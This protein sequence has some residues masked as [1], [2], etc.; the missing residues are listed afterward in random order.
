MDIREPRRSPLRNLSLVWLVPLLAL[1]VTLGVAWQNFADRGTLIQIAFD[2]AQGVLPGETA[3]RYRDVVVGRVKDVDFTTGL[4]R[5]LVSARID[6]DV[7]PYL[8]AD[9]DFWVVRPEVSARGIEGLSTVL[10]GVY[11]EGAWDGERGEARTAFDGRDGPPLVQP[12]RPGKRITLRTENGTTISKGAPVL[13]RGVQVG[14]LEAPRLAQGGGFVLVDAFVDAPH[15]AL[16]TGGVRFWDTSGF[17]V[18]FG[19]GGF[20]LDFDS[21]ASLVTGGLSFA[22][23]YDGGE[24]VDAGAVFDIFP[25]EQAARRS[26]F[27]P[28]AVGSVTLSVRFD[29]NVGGLNAGADVTFRGL[30]VGQVDGLQS[31]VTETDAGPEVELIA[32]ITV[33]PARIG[34]AADAGEDAVFDFF[35]EAVANGLR[36]RLSTQ[37]FFSRDL[38]VEIVELPEAAPAAFDRSAEPNPRLPS[39][40]SDLPDV[41]ATAQG[42]LDRVNDLPLEEVLDQ[43]ISLMASIEDVARS[44]GTRQTPDAVLALV[45]DTRALI[46]AEE[47]QA[48]PG[49]LNAIVADL[50]AV[51]A[52]LRE[53]GATRDLASALESLDAV[54]SDLAQGSD[55]LPE[56]LGNLQR[57][58]EEAAALDTRALANEARDALENLNALLSDEALQTLPPT[59]AD[60]ASRLRTILRDIDE[61]GAVARLNAALA[62]LETVGADAAAASDSLPELIENLRAFSE[63]ANGLES[64]ALVTQARSAL[65][66]L[67]ALLADEALRGL[68]PTIA[69]AAGSL[70]RTLQELDEGGAVTRLNAALANFETVSTDLAAAS[71]DVPGL[72][73]D[74]QTLADRT[75]GLDTEGLVQTA[76]SVLDSADRFVSSDDTQNVPP[77]L[78]GALNEV[79]AALAEL[80]EGGAVTNVN[81]AL[82]STR[83]AADAIATA[84]QDL[85]QLSERLDSLVRQAEAAI[86]TYGPRSEISGEALATLREL[87]DA[88]RAVTDLSR[89][90][91]R[92]PNSLLF[93]R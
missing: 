86:A 66:N 5:V 11:I 71:G 7:A 49:E 19:T 17:R 55:R 30:A 61:G 67:N 23:I 44:E 82:V 59:V 27:A 20:Q 56:I 76:Q 8:D 53:S 81:E 32:N 2:D 63:T 60:A 35:E 79:E 39:V 58:S 62:D 74:L 45:E 4:D 43:A 89:A 90:I 83:D 75:A 15:D 88:A 13:Y 41:T 72:L 46:A 42:V 65:E 37:S 87:R 16:L 28:G 51:V 92:S 1:A 47:T 40:E 48:L 6:S 33:D 10:S 24:P 21:I 9:A 57:F 77:A 70:R 3:L 54:A 38:I 26:L 34:L 36:A 64:E 22:T 14:E 84:A 85:P 52:E 91:E 50:R 25:D 73:E 12:G 69:D 80:R 18:S 68:P 29:E 93:G 78:I 31:V